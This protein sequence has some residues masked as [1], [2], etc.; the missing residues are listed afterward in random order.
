MGFEKR[1]IKR[2]LVERF[3]FHNLTYSNFCKLLEALTRIRASEKEDD[4]VVL[5]PSEALK[6]SRDGGLC[7]RCETRERNVLFLPC[8]HSICCLSCSTKL[9]SVCYMENKSIKESALTLFNLL[10]KRSVCLK[11][12]VYVLK[13]S[14]CFFRRLLF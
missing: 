7:K 14:R 4:K 10:E 6:V 3:K 8:S 1:E 9:G 5:T 12:F 11:Q 13:Y 2:V